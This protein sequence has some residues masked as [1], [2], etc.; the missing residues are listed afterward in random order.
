MRLSFKT[1]LFLSGL[2]FGGF[3]DHVFLAAM[4]AE[5]SPYGIAVGTLGNSLLAIFDLGLVSRRAL[6]TEEARC[7]TRLPTRARHDG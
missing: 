1:A 6:A 3:L 4:R 7:L 5:L 2:F